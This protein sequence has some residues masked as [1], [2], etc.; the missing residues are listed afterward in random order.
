MNCLPVALFA[1]AALFTSTLSAQEFEVPVNVTLIAKEDYMRYEQD[2]IKAAKWL[3][4]TPIG[5]EE[6]KRVR[7]NAFVLE[8]ITGS[9]S[10]TVVI[11]PIAG[12]LT[13]KNPHLLMVF[14]ASYTRW[15]LENNYSKDE[16]KGYQ[17]AV[18]S[19][20]NTYNLDGVIKKNRTLQKAAEAE[21][22]GKLDEWVKENYNKK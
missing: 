2:I 17:F 3:E 14:M 6:T 18:R 21:K 9:P 4:A 8:W 20:I 5:Q 22:S 13:E 10:V 19:V 11:Q 15:A 12:K 16:L 7:V 1:I